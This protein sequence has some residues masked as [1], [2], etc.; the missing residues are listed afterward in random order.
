MEQNLIMSSRIQARIDGRNKLRKSCCVSSSPCSWP[1][2]DCHH[3]PHPVGFFFQLWSRNTL[4]LYELT[5]KVM[6]V[7]AAICRRRGEEETQRQTGDRMEDCSPQWW[8][9]AENLQWT[10]HLLPTSVSSRSKMNP[11]TLES[12]VYLHCAPSAVFYTSLIT[13]ILSTE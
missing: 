5:F 9:Q 4:S 6:G 2:D 7:P 13:L 12:R 11:I 3:L 1:P 10:Q 8:G